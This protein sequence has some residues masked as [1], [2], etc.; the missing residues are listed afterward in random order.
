M[1]EQAKEEKERWEKERE[2]YFREREARLVAQKENEEMR[3]RLE[4][5]Q[6]ELERY[7]DSL[8]RTEERTNLLAEKA[9]IAEE[10][11]GLLLRKAADLE[12]E[13]YRLNISMSQKEA[14]KAFLEGKIREHELTIRSVLDQS[15]DSIKNADGLKE[16]LERA[17]KAEKL[18][19]EKLLEVTSCHT[20]I[21]VKRKHEAK[22]GGPGALENGQNAVLLSTEMQ[23][24]R[25]EY[26]QKSKDLQKQLTELKTEIEGLKVAGK[27]DILDLMH[28]ENAEKG[29]SKY[30]T[31]RKVTESSTNTRVQFFERL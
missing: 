24:E 9:L 25:V 7:R 3:M 27:Q 23:Q 15:E 11:S 2:R 8:I 31:L 29:E 6:N 5:Y 16:E 26:L 20:L 1:R 13:I 30:S 19:K 18:A 14:Q 4:E 22:D 28:L 10:E 17:R 12:N 21:P